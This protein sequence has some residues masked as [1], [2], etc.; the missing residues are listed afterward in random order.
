VQQLTPVQ[1]KHAKR[2]L[3]PKVNQ[4]GDEDV[5]DALGE[6]IVY[7]CPTRR[8]YVTEIFEGIL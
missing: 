8:R 7:W 4:P 3:P 2:I 5:V 6:S 1:P